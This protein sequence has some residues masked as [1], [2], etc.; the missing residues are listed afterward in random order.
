MRGGVKRAFCFWCDAPLI[1]SSWNY[2]WFSGDKSTHC[3]PGRLHLASE[4]PVQ[5]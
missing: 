4:T 5:R 2:H 1:W 3:A